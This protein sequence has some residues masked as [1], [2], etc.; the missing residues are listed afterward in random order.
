[1]PDEIGIDRTHILDE[2]TMRDIRAVIEAA[3]RRKAHAIMPQQDYGFG[4]GPQSSMGS[5]PSAASHYSS[6]SSFG[7]NVSQPSAYGQ[8]LPR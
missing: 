3:E 1:M 5:L 8:M 7:S 2:E 6:T 4:V